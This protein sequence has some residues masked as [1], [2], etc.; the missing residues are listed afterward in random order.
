[1]KEGPPCVEKFVPKSI[2]KI[3][4]QVTLESH[5]HPAYITSSLLGMYS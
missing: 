5:M 1:M 3:I 2:P 4:I